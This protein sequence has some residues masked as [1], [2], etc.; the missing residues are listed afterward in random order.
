MQMLNPP[1]RATRSY[2][3]MDEIDGATPFADPPRVERTEAQRDRDFRDACILLGMQYGVPQRR[4][5]RVLGL[6][7]VGIL[8]AAR[9]MKR[10]QSRV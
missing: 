3:D 8:K 5:A 2:G 6:S 9:R 10:R 7:Q 1:R 4:M